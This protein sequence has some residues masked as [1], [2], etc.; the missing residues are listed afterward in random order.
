[1]LQK[2]LGKKST[3]TGAWR[4][5][6]GKAGCWLA[7]EWFTQLCHAAF[8]QELCRLLTEQLPTMAASRGMEEGWGLGVPPPAHSFLQHSGDCK[9]R[10]AF[11]SAPFPALLFFPGCF[12]PCGALAF[13]MGKGDVTAARAGPWHRGGKQRAKVWKDRKSSASLRKTPPG[14]RF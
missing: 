12:C 7:G 9:C 8:Q 6:E 10:S 5:P 4:Q 3:W 2:D 11:S 14:K 1:M 13:Q